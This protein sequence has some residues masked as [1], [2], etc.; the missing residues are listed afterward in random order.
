MYY[1]S[2]TNVLLLLLLSSSSSSLLLTQVLGFVFIACPSWFMLLPVSEKWTGQVMCGQMISLRI[3]EF[4]RNTATTCNNNNVFIH[5]T[6][7]R[8]IKRTSRLKTKVLL[9]TAVSQKLGCK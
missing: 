7:Q 4:F 6:Y 1:A 5:V 9:Q 8:H 3:G 2:N